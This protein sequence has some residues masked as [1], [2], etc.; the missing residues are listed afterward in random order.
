[1]PHSAAVTSPNRHDTWRVAPPLAGLGLL[2][3]AYVIPLVRFSNMGHQGAFAAS[4]MPGIW[5]VYP[6]WLAAFAGLAFATGRSRAAG[7]LGTA[8]GLM[9]TL[10]SGVVAFVLM[11]IPRAVPTGLLPEP[12]RRYVPE[13][14]PGPAAFLSVLGCGLV[15]LSC[16]L[17]WTTATRLRHTSRA[18]RGQD[19]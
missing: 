18:L 1:M 16:L 7:V 5:L 6:L 8:Y 4:E 2:V 19:R 11:A 10:A 12:A 3:G 13:L 14:V 17:R 15:T 9:S